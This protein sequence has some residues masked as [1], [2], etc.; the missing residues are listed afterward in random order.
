MAR[1]Y[2]CIILESRGPDMEWR[3]LG[4]IAQGWYSKFN[5]AA[6]PSDTGFGDSSE[7]VAAFKS[8][9]AAVLIGYH[10]AVLAE[11]KKYLKGLE[12]EDLG[13][14]LDEPYNPPPT[15]GA[16]ITSILAD[17]PGHAGE[18]DYLRGLLSGKGW[19]GY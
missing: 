15:V 3:D 18:V 13:R 5:R 12:D 9:A 10:G 2:F 1:T 17:C 14:M 6:D 19:L 8:P 16:R 4:W 7:D 11:T